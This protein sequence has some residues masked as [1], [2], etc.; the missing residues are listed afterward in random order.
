MPRLRIAAQSLVS[1]RRFATKKRRWARETAP[2]SPYSLAICRHRER[3]LPGIRHCLNRRFGRR[4]PSKVSGW[5]DQMATSPLP[6][7]TTPSMRLTH[8]SRTSRKS[9]PL[10]RDSGD[11]ACGYFPP[12]SITTFKEVLQTSSR[13]PLLCRNY[14]NRMGFAASTYS[15]PTKE[16]STTR[17]GNRLRPARRAELT[18]KSDQ[19]PPCQAIIP[20][21]FRSQA[22]QPTWRRL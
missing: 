14:D 17:A 22:G 6:R 9:L 21:V 13:M 2:A 19:F 10:R 11:T 3:Y 4:M 5:F 15:S 16:S 12:L 18:F 7:S 8:I 20:T 1:A